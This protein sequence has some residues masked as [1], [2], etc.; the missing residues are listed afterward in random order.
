MVIIHD[1]YQPCGPLTS[2]PVTHYINIMLLIIGA[3]HDSGSTVCATQ[4]AAYDTTYCEHKGETR[5][6]L[7]RDQSREKR[8]KAPIHE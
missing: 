5:S 7:G 3:Q 2:V 6:T 8:L 1:A 4:C